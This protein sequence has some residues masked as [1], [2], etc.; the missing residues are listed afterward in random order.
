MQTGTIDV[1]S[2]NMR[3]KAN[4]IRL[5]H[6]T[7]SSDQIGI[8]QPLYPETYKMPRAHNTKSTKHC[9]SSEPSIFETEKRTILP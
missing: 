9:S 3:I 5:Q 7:S 8:N 6:L 2:S 1:Y 4:H